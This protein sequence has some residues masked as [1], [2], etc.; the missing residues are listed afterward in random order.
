[1]CTQRERGQRDR[2]IGAWEAGR[3]KWRWREAGRGMKAQRRCASRDENTVYCL[4]QHHLVAL[5]NFKAIT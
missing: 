1:V 2:E 3:E 5:S 4:A